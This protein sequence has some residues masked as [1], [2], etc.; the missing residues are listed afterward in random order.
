[1]KYKIFF[2]LIITILA[3]I[4]AVS[5]LVKI[6]TGMT[7]GE[8]PV[9]RWKFAIYRGECDDE[10]GC[11][12]SKMEE[13]GVAEYFG[14][15]KI[16]CYGNDIYAH[17]NINSN[18]KKIN[19][20]DTLAISPKPMANGFVREYSADSSEIYDSKYEDINGCRKVVEWKSYDKNLRI[21]SEWIKKFKVDSTQTCDF[22]AYT[23]LKKEYKNE[24]LISVKEY[25]ALSEASEEE[26]SGTWKYYNSKGK[27]IKTENFTLKKIKVIKHQ[28]KK[29][30][31]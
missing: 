12:F 22:S 4:F 16:S 29:L 25:S 6:D 7:C 18:E 15:K 28:F 13:N 10:T 23:T 5:Y 21:K 8:S 31:Q 24:K 26:P 30:K 17:K 3:I 2:Y 9:V 11:H 19:K 1:M 27:L 14:L 20:N